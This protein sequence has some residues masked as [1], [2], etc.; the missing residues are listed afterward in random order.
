MGA[1]KLL[2]RRFA[3]GANKTLVGASKKF[4]RRSKRGDLRGFVSDHGYENAVLGGGLAAGGFAASRKANAEKKIRKQMRT[5]GVRFSGETYKDLI[6]FSMQ[7]GIDPS[8]VQSLIT[9]AARIE[10]EGQTKIVISRQLFEQ[11]QAA[12]QNFQIQKQQIDGASAQRMQ[13]QGFE[14]GHDVIMFGRTQRLKNFIDTA[15]GKFVREEA[16]KLKG[17][18]KKKGTY[19]KISSLDPFGFEPNPAY[20][21]QQI[22]EAYAI[23]DMKKA[24][25]KL[26]KAGKKA[27]IAAGTGAGAVGAYKLGKRKKDAGR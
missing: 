27:A 21:N 1:T 18:P 5:G 11:L 14:A 15:R 22:K 4:G 26:K 20:S 8:I 23:R 25:A 3:K 16:E 9:E 17:I 6:E 10:Q 13:E 12:L 24:R 2:A 7:P 19:Q